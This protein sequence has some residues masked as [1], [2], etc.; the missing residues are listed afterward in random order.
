MATRIFKD[1]LKEFSFEEKLCQQVDEK[2]F[3]SDLWDISWLDSTGKHM[4]HVQNVKDIMK[5]TGIM[6]TMG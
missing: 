3:A 6:M 5:D 2:K 1:N 4:D